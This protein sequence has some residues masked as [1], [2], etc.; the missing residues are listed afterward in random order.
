M[1]TQ[2][3]IIEAIK[4]LIL[5]NF[6]R[7][8]MIAAPAFLL[9]YI[10]FRN[11][12]AFK[13]IQSVFP[14]RKDYLREFGYSMLTVLMFTLVAFFTFAPQLRPYHLRYDHI[15]DYGWVYWVISIVLMLLIHDTYFYW[16]HRVMHHPKLFRIFHAVHH[17][18]TNPSPWASYAFHPL[19]GIVEA[20]VIVPIVFLIPFH[21]SA[22]F[23]FLMIMMSYNVYG[24]LGYELFPKGFNNHYIGR[25]LNTS[26]NHNQHHQYF[27]GNYGLYFLFWDRWMGTLREDYDQEYQQ[28]DLKINAFKKRNSL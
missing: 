13:K 10:L 7:Y 22:M 5:I 9:F 1:D 23:V 2:Q 28:Y 24:H 21:A 4:G 8:A 11:K 18:S 15:S 12:W 17:Q 14:K 16:T 25:W 6:I 26:I 20:L 19:E 27:I 3:V